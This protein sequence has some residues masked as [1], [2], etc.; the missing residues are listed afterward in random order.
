MALIHFFTTKYGIALLI[1]LLAGVS[2]Y[3]YRYF[4]NRKKK[5]MPVFKANIFEALG[6]NEPS[7]RTNLHVAFPEKKD[8]M[9]DKTYNRF[10]VEPK[11]EEPKKEEPKQEPHIEHESEFEK[12]KKGYKPKGDEFDFDLRNAIISHEILKKKQ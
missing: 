10:K 12:L 3:Y 7:G 8:A 9:S 6:K 1:L 11:K 2:Y 4:K 5:P